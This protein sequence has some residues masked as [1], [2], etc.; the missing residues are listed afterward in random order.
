MDIVYSPVQSIRWQIPPPHRGM[1]GPPV[2]S[3][4]SIALYHSGIRN[5]QSAG[6]GES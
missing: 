1:E 2:K 4:S 3:V 5:L 6:T